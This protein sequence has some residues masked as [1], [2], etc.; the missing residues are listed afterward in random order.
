MK[1]HKTIDHKGYQINIYFDDSPMPPN[2]GD[3]DDVFLI[4]DHRSFFVK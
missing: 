4:H 3:N 1:P 2:D